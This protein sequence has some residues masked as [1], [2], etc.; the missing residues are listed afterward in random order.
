MKSLPS[1]LATSSCRLFGGADFSPS[2]VIFEFTLFNHFIRAG[3]FRRGCHPAAAAYQ[4]ISR[5]IGRIAALQA[6]NTQAGI[7]ALARKGGWS[8]GSV[9]P[10]KRIFSSGISIQQEPAMGPGWCSTIRVIPSGYREMQWSKVISG[11]DPAD[12]PQ[13]V[14]L[15]PV[16]TCSQVLVFKGQRAGAKSCGGGFVG[17]QGSFHGP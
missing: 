1:K 8:T 14:A 12:C 5:Y 10:T 4:F 7:S 13:I 15:F 16:S 6:S 17:D 2:S 11:G 3:I 9:S